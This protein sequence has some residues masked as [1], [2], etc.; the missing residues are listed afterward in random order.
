MAKITKTNSKVKKAKS[1]QKH[2]IVKIHF[3]AKFNNSIITITDLQD[4]VLVW[5]SSGKIGFKGSKKATPFAAQKATEDVLEKLKAFET[6]NVSIIIKGPG[7]GRDSFI[8]FVQNSDLQI[9]SIKDA[10]GFP[11]GGVSP[12]KRRRV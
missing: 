7:M 8:R 3:A 2:P 11:F 12:K 4:K 6:T 10:T 1:K 5:S 9:D